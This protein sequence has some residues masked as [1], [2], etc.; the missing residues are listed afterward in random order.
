M[1]SAG[2]PVPGATMATVE[3][4]VSRAQRLMVARSMPPPWNDTGMAGAGTVRPGAPGGAAWALVAR[5]VVR[6]TVATNR[7][8]VT[9]LSVMRFPCLAMVWLVWVHVMPVAGFL[10]M[11]WRG[12]CL[13]RSGYG[14]ASCPPGL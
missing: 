13:R 6:V 14:P 2:N 8:R 4:H 10:S 9:A 5:A 12:S 11:N 3:A 7:V 1:L